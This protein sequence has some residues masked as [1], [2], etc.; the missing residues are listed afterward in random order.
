[1]DPETWNYTL[2]G[3][4]H[5]QI[6]SKGLLKK[7]EIPLVSCYFDKASWYTITTRRILG[8]YYTHNIA[9]EVISVIEDH[10]GNFKG[11]GNKER[12]VY[13]VK[14]KDTPEIRFEYE[15]GKASMAPI[16]ALR[17]LIKKIGKPNTE[18]DDVL[19]D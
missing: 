6:E 7:E 4:L 11:F 12:E 18:Q 14:T 2:I 3:E 13:T 19:N 15:T 10:S 17:T 16:Y 1:M 9:V 8:F 5:P